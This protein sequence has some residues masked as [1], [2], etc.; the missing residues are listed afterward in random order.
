MLSVALTFELQNIK[1]YISSLYRQKIKQPV[2][3]ES[4]VNPGNYTIQSD[5]KKT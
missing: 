4:L 3:L 1:I 2:C 5:A